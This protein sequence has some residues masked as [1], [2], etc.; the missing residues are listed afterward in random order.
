MMANDTDA[1][2]EV[3][4]MSHVTV[5]GISMGGR[6][7]LD[8]ALEPPRPGCAADPGEHQGVGEA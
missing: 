3:V 8:L 6:I 1:L 7:A 4:G 2:M 5:L